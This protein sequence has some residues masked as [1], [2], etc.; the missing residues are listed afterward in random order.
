MT[1]YPSTVYWMLHSLHTYLTNL[2]TKERKYRKLFEN[3]TFG[4]AND[5]FR[6][7]VKQWLNVISVTNGE[8]KNF[9]LHASLSSEREQ[10]QWQSEGLPADQL[11]KQN[12]IIILR[13]CSLHV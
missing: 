7:L 9:S 13:V 6:S 11:S 8:N 2:R 10:L 5:Y 12:A 3:E 1:S 4:G